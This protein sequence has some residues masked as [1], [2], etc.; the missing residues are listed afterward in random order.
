[1]IHP[2]GERTRGGHVISRNP[3]WKAYYDTRNRVYMALRTRH[4]V[5]E[6]LLAIRFGATQ[7]ARELLLNPAYGIPN[8]RMR[9]KGLVDALRGRMGKTVDPA[10]TR[11]PGTSNPR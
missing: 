3:P 8:T 6:A 1:M 4:S 11:D 9:A 5:S 10:R 7:S 2:L